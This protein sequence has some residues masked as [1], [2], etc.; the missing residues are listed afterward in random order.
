MK[1]TAQTVRWFEDEQKRFGTGTALKNFQF[2][3][4]DEL[5]RGIGV[6]QVSVK[7]QRRAKKSD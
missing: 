7:Y 4:A 3:L 5:L 2:T 1:H 6:R